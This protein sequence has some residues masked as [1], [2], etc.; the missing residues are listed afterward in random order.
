MRPYDDGLQ[1]AILAVQQTFRKR[2][3]QSLIFDERVGRT[4][5][6]RLELRYCCFCIFQGRLPQMESDYRQGDFLRGRAG[7]ET[8]EV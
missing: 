6:S 1:V 8:A 5:P 3:F 4:D 2:Q 7:T